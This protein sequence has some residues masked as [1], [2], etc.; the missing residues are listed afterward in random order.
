MAACEW[1]PGEGTGWNQALGVN[2]GRGHVGGKG[3]EAFPL[4]LESLTCWDLGALL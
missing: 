3:V 2:V 4:L 1:C